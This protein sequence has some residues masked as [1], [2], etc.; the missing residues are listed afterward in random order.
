[1]DFKLICLSVLKSKAS[2]ETKREIEGRRGHWFRK[3]QKERELTAAKI[4][5][6]NTKREI[7]TG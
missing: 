7:N 6:F 2:G 3:I 5:G 1:M 4:E